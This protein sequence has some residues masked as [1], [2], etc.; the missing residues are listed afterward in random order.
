MPHKLTNKGK[1]RR[2]VRSL[3]KN[4]QKIEEMADIFLNSANFVSHGFF[5]FI[6]RNRT[7]LGF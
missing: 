5:E 3:D 7:F 2:F 1:R 4:N 6:E